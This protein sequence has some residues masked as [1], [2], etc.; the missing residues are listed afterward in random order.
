MS[1]LFLGLI[2]VLALFF[3]AFWVGP[4]LWVLAIVLLVLVLAWFVGE[5]RRSTLSRAGNPTNTG[6]SPGSAEPPRQVPAPD[7]V[8]V[9][10]E[11][12]PV[13]RRS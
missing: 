6:E 2:A 7:D 10:A 1:M 8:P 5:R 13:S 9:D 12:E 4:A 3:A 11:G